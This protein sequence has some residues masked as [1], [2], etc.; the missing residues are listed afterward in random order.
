MGGLAGCND[1]I[2][3]RRVLAA[4][5]AGEIAF[6]QD[7]FEV[8]TAFV[9]ADDSSTRLSFGAASASAECWH[10]P[11][12]AVIRWFEDANAA[13]CSFVCYQMRSFA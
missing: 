9:L 3:R 1:L 12:G 2:R 7:R 5:C 13:S 10:R 8:S 6:P 11:E 4:A